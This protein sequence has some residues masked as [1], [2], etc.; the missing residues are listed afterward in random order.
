MGSGLKNG[1]RSSGRGREGYR[2]WVIE[3]WRMRASY[4][5]MGYMQ[6]EDGE[7]FTVGGML[8]TVMPG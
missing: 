1:D 3:M 6:R 7:D 4:S 2:N 8:G 5:K